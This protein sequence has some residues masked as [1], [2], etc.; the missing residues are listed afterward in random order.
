MFRYVFLNLLTK[1]SLAP[2]SYQ[3]ILLSSY[4]SCLQG[5]QNAKIMCTC[6]PKCWGLSCDTCC[7]DALH[8]TRGVGMGAWLAESISRSHVAAASALAYAKVCK[9]THT[10]IHF[11]HFFFVFL[12]FFPFFLALFHALL[13]ARSALRRCRFAMQICLHENEGSC[14]PDLLHHSPPPS[15]S[16]GHWGVCVSFRIC[17]KCTA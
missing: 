11:V 9:H 1:Q 16:L 4:V 15:D 5:M 12:H 2:L 13:K 8:E 7:H 3:C 10:R 17:I 14:C 6:L